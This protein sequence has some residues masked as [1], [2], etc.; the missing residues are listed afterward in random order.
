[1]SAIQVVL[2]HEFAGEVVEVGP[3]VSNVKV[4]DRVCVEPIY[5]CGECAACKRG[6]YNI[7]EKVGFIGLSGGSGGF[8]EYSVAPAKMVHKIPDEMSY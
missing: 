7:C 1:M 5:N 4:G 8:P 2:G 6:S 3:G